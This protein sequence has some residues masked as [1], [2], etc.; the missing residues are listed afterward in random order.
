[1]RR[2]LLAA[3]AVL[4]LAAAPAHAALVADATGDFLPSFAGPPDADLDVISFSVAF[5]DVADMFR[6]SAAMAGDIDPGRPG[7]Y[8]IGVNTGTGVIAPFG[9][10]GAP[11]V[12]FNQA[13]VIQKTGAALLSGKRL[14]ADIADTC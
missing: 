7:L 13:I 2:V 6:L 4:A 1:M 12:I 3:G 11:N 5:D 14:V 9:G 8:V 10:I